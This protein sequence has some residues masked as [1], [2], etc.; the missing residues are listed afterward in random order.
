MNITGVVV[1]SNTKDLIQKAYESVRKFHPDMQI[2]IIDGSYINDPCY[3]YVCSLASHIT[4]VGVYRYNIGHGRGMHAGINM[5]ETKYAL[6]FDSDIEMLQSPVADMIYMMNE[7]TYGVGAFDYVDNRGFGKHN[8]SQQWRD[9]ATKYLHPFFQIINVANYY[10][11]P[12]YT[13]HGA[14][15]FKA[16]NEIKRRGLSDKILIEYPGLSI[17]NREGEPGGLLI[18][19]DA[20]GTRSDRRR[21]GLIEIEQKWDR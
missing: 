19:H 3:S 10:K 8:H 9:E 2:I 18:R 11:F 4:T 12:Q 16:M 17:V 20:A 13:H 6:I 1:C 5:V 14:P 21:K 7:D 15:C